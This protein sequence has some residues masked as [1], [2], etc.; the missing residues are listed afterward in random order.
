MDHSRRRDW[1]VPQALEQEFALRGLVSGLPTWRG[2]G[3]TEREMDPCRYRVVTVGLGYIPKVTKDI[4]R[5]RLE[6]CPRD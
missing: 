2:S 4:P 6:C 5:L 3:G 1:S